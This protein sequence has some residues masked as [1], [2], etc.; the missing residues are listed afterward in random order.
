VLH[1]LSGKPQK[2]LLKDT[3]DIYLLKLY[4]IIIIIIIIIFL[5]FSIKPISYNL[6]NK[7]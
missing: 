5:K 3:A 6:T 7:V 1:T 4:L 2:P